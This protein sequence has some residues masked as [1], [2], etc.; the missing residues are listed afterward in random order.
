MCV[1]RSLRLDCRP[2]MGD[3]LTPRFLKS[4]TPF[5]ARFVAKS[6][7]YDIRSAFKN[8]T[9][10]LPFIDGTILLFNVL[11]KG[12]MGRNLQRNGGR[13]YHYTFS[14]VVPIEEICFEKKVL[15]LIRIYELLSMQSLTL[16]LVDK[17]KSFA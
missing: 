14:D 9:L 5:G 12:L 16:F 17:F 4:S 8:Q 11:G 2:V 10:T 15:V 6:G 13:F 7:A 1:G 3:N